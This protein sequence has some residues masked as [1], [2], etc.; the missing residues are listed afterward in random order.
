MRVELRAAD[1]EVD[2]ADALE[3][4]VHRRPAGSVLVPGL[5]DAAVRAQLL[6]V[7]ARELVQVR[8]ADLLLAL[9]QHADPERQRTDGR[10]VR[11]DGLEPRHEIALVVRGAA[12]EQQP[13]ARGRLE[14][15]RRPLAEGVGRLD[16]EVVVDEQG[17]LATPLLADD[18]GGSAGGALGRRGEAGPRRPRKY[19]AGGLLDGAVLRRYG[20]QADERGELFD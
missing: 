10:L 19:R 2:V 16:V 7:R 11:L 9:E 17:A 14:R 15:R 6:R 20:R 3:P 1:D 18:R 13:V 12:A 4:E 5:P 8:R